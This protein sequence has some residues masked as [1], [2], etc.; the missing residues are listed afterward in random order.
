MLYMLRHMHIQSK[1][2]H[3]VSC[4]YPLTLIQAEATQLNDLTMCDIHRISLTALYDILMCLFS[5]GFVNALYPL[6]RPG[7]QATV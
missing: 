1:V 6:V 3:V 2:E 4:H 5:S 7:K